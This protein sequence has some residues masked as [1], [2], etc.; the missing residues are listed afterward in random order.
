[1]YSTSTNIKTIDAFANQAEEIYDRGFGKHVLKIKLTGANG[2]AIS[3][4]AQNRRLHI[5]GV[6]AFDSR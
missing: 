5:L 6:Y 3:P 1:M 2:S 4:V